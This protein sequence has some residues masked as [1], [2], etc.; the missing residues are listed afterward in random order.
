MA[1]SKIR[2]GNTLVSLF[3]SFSVL[4][5]CYSSQKEIDLFIF[6]IMICKKQKIVIVCLK[7]SLDLS[8]KRHSL[9]DCNDENSNLDLSVFTIF[10]SNR[11]LV[12]GEDSPESKLTDHFTKSSTVQQ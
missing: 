9:L 1:S 4:D 7:L 3:I 6:V 8:A 12:R 5:Y 10:R 2:Q 11:G